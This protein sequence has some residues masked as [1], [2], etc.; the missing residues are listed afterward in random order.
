MTNAG[1]ATGLRSFPAAGPAGDGASTG[2]RGSCGAGAFVSLGS[3]PRA[4]GVPWE[5]AGDK[6]KTATREVGH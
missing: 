6:G 1:S 4:P 2:P 3:M 5:P